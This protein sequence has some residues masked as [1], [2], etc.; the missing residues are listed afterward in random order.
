MWCRSARASTANRTQ[1]TSAA[2]GLAQSQRCRVRAA[3][4]RPES[5]TLGL[6]DD[7]V[8]EALKQAAGIH[9]QSL[10]IEEKRPTPCVMSR[11][12]RT[13][14]DQFL[15]SA[16]IVGESGCLSSPQ[17]GSTR[18]VSS[19]NPAS[20]RLLVVGVRLGDPG[21]PRDAAA[22]SRSHPRARS[23]GDAARAHGRKPTRAC[24]RPR[25]GPGSGRVLRPPFA[26]PDAKA[27]STGE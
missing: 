13:K 8:V 5:T 7:R 3:R 21:R 12:Q 15:C 2:N 16:S 6:A 9:L 23:A 17:T 14:E 1:S 24:R 11:F 18:A 27:E 20:P 22:C 25:P 4:P 10:A 26:K 19:L